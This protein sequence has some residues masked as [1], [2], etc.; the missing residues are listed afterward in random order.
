MLYIYGSFLNDKFINELCL[1]SVLEL[2]KNVLGEARNGFLKLSREEQFAVEGLELK[3]KNLFKLYI[4]DWCA[5]KWSADCIKQNIDQEIQ[6]AIENVKNTITFKIGKS[7]MFLP[8]KIKRI[9][10]GY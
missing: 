3:E 10:K 2:Q 8:G 4:V 7:I 5:Q 1:E 9:I 6:K